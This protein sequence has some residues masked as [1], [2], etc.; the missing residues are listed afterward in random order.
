MDSNAPASPG[1][2]MKEIRYFRTCQY[3][4]EREFIHPDYAGD[5]QIVTRLTGKKTIDSATRELLRDLTGGFLFWTEVP[6]PRQ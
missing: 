3:G 4:V 6:A 2:N 1:R 5:S